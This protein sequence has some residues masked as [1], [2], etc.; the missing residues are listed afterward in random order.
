MIP[1]ITPGTSGTFSVTIKSSDS[2][3]VFTPVPDATAVAT[4][5]DPDH[6]V[7][8]AD[9]P[10]VARPGGVYALLLDPAW[11][12]PNGSPHEGTYIIEVSATWQGKSLYDEFPIKVTVDA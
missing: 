12:M 4:V 8:A 3:G 11:T 10:M 1:K 7:I 6:R 9:V 5:R 2:A